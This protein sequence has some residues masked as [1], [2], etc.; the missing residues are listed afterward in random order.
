[1]HS[2]PRTVSPQNIVQCVA[3]AAA[4][5]ATALPPLSAHSSELDSRDRLVNLAHER[6]CFSIG[7]DVRWA[8]PSF[9]DQQWSR[10][11]PRNAW[12]DEGYEGY[13]GYAWY[14]CE[15]DF[16][17]RTD[18]AT[19]LVLGRIDDVDEVFVNGRKIGSTGKFPPDYVSAYNQDRTYLIP[20]GTWKRGAGNVI[21]VRVYDAGGEGGM[22]DGPVGIYTTELPVPA[23]D[24]MGE[25]Q[26]QPGDNPAWKDEQADTSGFKPLAVPGYWEHAGY[27][28]LDGLAW[29]R[30]SFDFAVGGAAETMVLMLGKIDDT[31]EVYLNG[32]K[33]GSTGK[34]RD[35]DQHSGVDYYDQQRGYYFSSSLL[36]AHNV[37]AVRVHDHGGLGGIYEGPVG[38]IS[39]ENYSAYWESARH[40]RRGHGL[41][42]LLRT[43]SDD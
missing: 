13:N 42:W 3:L 12:E 32:T 24:L 5:F 18:H 36:K 38:I 11:H 30:K 2:T 16:N 17:E 26:F 28:Q 15:F 40:H 1:M 29:Y 20:A 34:L 14:R 39:Q 37:I 7:D 19:Y 22:V 9:Q 10:I 43:L 4:F 25:W 35:S 6:W 31:D 21:A 8:E 41:R 23:V 33:I 27:D